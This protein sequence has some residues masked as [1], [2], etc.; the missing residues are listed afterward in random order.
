[1][2][3][4]LKFQWL[5]ARYAWAGSYTV[6]NTWYG[7]WGPVLVYAW[8]RWR[9]HPLTLP[10]RLDGY[11]ILLAF[12]F[13]GATWAG[14]LI[15]RFL[16]APARLYWEQHKKVDELEVG[17]SAATK[18]HQDDGP[19]WAIDELFSHIDP[20]LL[21]RTDPNVGDTWDEIGNKI[22]DQAALGRLHIWGRPMRDGPDS[23][24]GQRITPRLIEPDYWT[25]AY[26]TYSFFDSE[27]ADDA[28]TYLEVGRSG[29]QYSDLQVNKAEALRLWPG[30]PADIAE[31]YANVRVADNPALI[32]LF[33]VRGIKQNKLLALL[34]E[35]K[36]RSWAKNSIPNYDYHLYKLDPSIWH[37][38]KLTFQRAVS[39]RHI[40]QTFLGKEKTYAWSTPTNSH[41]DVWLNFAEMKR[42]WP[43]L[44]IIMAT[45]C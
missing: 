27:A 19:N 3:K 33:T 32:E 43:D 4:F 41:Y 23:I 7:L 25:I 1:M 35:G 11:A 34:Q 44:Q 39:D 37:Q 26:F 18:E 24:L 16:I 36:L 21:S 13:L 22:R 12:V 40:N 17:L 15:T 20:E 42:I 9:G 29:V 30:E 45:K 10:D 6:A 38:K 31:S 5:S 2:R 28:H 14:L 8:S